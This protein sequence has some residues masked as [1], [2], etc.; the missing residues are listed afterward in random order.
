MDYKEETRQLTPKEILEKIMSL[1]EYNMVPYTTDPLGI[2]H[3][4]CGG[5]EFSLKEGSICV[6][7]SKIT[8]HSVDYVTGHIESVDDFKE[9]YKE[10]TSKDLKDVP[11]EFEIFNDI[12]KLIESSNTPYTKD[13]IGNVHV[14]DIEMALLQE[15]DGTTVIKIIYK[16]LPDPGL[17]NETRAWRVNSVAEF[18]RLYMT[19]TGT[20]LKKEAQKSSEDIYEKMERGG[21]GVARR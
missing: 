8:D 3:L 2:I 10:M 5:V 21:D 1:I 14:G 11:E 17:A 16:N 15:A 13:P 6:G 4:E 9:L 20:Q 18:E 7:Y 12:I 19:L